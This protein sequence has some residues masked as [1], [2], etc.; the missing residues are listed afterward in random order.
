MTTLLDMTQDIMERVGADSVNSISDTPESLRF[1]GVIKDS[2]NHIL[3]INDLR[4]AHTL[5]DITASG[6]TNLPVLM[7]K[8]DD[9]V[10]IDW[11]KYNKI[12]D[13]ETEDKWEYLTFLPLDEFMEK[14]HFYA[15]LDD[16]NTNVQTMTISDTHI[17]SNTIYYLDDEGPSYFTIVDNRFILFNAFDSAVDSTIQNSKLLA[18]GKKTYTFSMTDAFDFTPLDSLQIDYLYNEAKTQAFLEIKQ[19]E[20]KQA[21]ARAKRGAVA[22]QHNSSV[23]QLYEYGRNDGLPNY[24]RKK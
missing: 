24:S 10:E 13:G 20:N 1:A 17:A 21:Q 2:Y 19:L 18:M 23:I 16:E 15:Q 4:E 5:L 12:E 7:Y 3:A 9:V 14:S 11:M 8:P 6:D 22:A